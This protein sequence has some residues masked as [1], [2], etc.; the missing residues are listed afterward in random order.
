MTLAHIASPTIVILGHVCIDENVIE[1][2]SYSSWGSP[3]MYIAAYY[4][5]EYGLRTHIVSEYGIDFTKYIYTFALMAIPP[6]SNDTLIYRNL[7]Q[8]GHRTQYCPNPE[9]SPP[10]ELSDSVVNIIKMAD[11]LI[12]APDIPNYSDVYIRQAVSHAKQNCKKILLPQ[13][14]L[15]KIDNTLIRRG[16]LNDPSILELFDAVIISDEDIDDVQQMAMIWSESFTKTTVVVTREKHG[17]DLFH[18][19]KLLTVPTHSLSRQEIINP[20]GAGDIFSAEVAMKLF[21]GETMERSVQ[22]AH[23][24][25]AKILS[26][27]S[28]QNL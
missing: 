9:N 18:K 13:G 11:I 2:I 15:R 10:V 22:S 7:V 1:G 8:N 3:A 23:R 12:I 24:S 25:T 20:I 21:E 5:R 19:G 26:S 28:R 6:R 4:A 27:R 16:T 14:L 17:A